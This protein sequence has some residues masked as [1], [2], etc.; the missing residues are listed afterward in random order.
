MAVVVET[1]F[2]YSLETTKVFI[3]HIRMV[4]MSILA[5]KR[6]VHYSLWSSTL[7]FIGVP[8]LRFTTRTIRTVKAWQPA[9]TQIRRRTRRLIMVYI[10]C[11]KSSFR[12]INLFT[13]NCHCYLN[14]LDRSFYKRTSIWYNV[15][16]DQ[17]P[18]SAASDLGPHCLPITLLWVEQWMCKYG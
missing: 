13:A 17:T 2:K 8:Y 7:D 14:F 11:N 9:C 15:D 16:P 5:Y 1:D 6:K 18:R 12:N 10:V 4:C 3:S